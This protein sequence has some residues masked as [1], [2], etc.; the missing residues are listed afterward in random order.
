MI[1]FEWINKFSNKWMNKQFIKFQL[2]ISVRFWITWQIINNKIYENYGTKF[3]KK[4]FQFKL[5]IINFIFKFK[6]IYFPF[7]KIF[8]ESFT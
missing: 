8:F 1:N 3:K 2:N 5:K 7:K 6:K 4:Y